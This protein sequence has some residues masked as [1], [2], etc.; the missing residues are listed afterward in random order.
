MDIRISEEEQQLLEK[1][2]QLYNLTIEQ[3]IELVMRQHLQRL[4]QLGKT[5]TRHS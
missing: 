1:A 2:A 3:Y 4:A 5:N